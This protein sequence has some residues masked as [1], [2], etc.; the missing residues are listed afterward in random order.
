MFTHKVDMGEKK[1]EINEIYSCHGHGIK[2]LDQK[3]CMFILALK[4]MR[5]EH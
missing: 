4:I 2:W 3:V 1:E 5:T